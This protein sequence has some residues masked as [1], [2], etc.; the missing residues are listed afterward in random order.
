ME[1]KTNEIQDL[2]PV[3]ITNYEDLKKELIEKTN[4]YK[5][6]VYSEKNIK[7]AKTDR[8]NLNKLEKAINEEKI[9]VKNI[10]LKPYEDFETKCKELMS[11]VKEASTNIDTQVKAFEQKQ[12]AEKKE[13]ILGRFNTLMGEYVEV[14]SF[15]KIFNPKWLNKTY[16]FSKIEEDIIHLRNQITTDLATLNEQVQDVTLLSQLKDFY[17]KNITEP[18]VLAVTLAEKNRI[19]ENQKKIEKLE[20]ETKK[21]AEEMQAENAELEYDRNAVVVDF[22]VTASK[23]QLGKLKNFLKENN[24]KYEKVP[25]E[26]DFYLDEI[27][28]YVEECREGGET[29]DWRDVLYYIEELRTRNGGK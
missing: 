7:D 9:R 27:Q 11:L 8:A 16:T 15:E 23:E 19:I 17:L 13:I 3:V 26:V 14:V 20:N 1:I 29:S 12:D 21:I 28:E 5:N 24:I 6:I 2:V 10:F 25:N 4:I 22:R 18:N